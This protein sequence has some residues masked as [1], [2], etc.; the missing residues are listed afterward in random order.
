[1]RSTFSKFCEHR[2]CCAA[3]V[4]AIKLERQQPGHTSECVEALIANPVA[5]QIQMPER[6]QRCKSLRR[7]VPNRVVP[8]IKLGQ[9]RQV[10]SEHVSTPVPN[11]VVMQ[12]QSAQGG[13]ARKRLCT[14]VAHAGRV[15][16]QVRHMGQ[17]ARAPNDR[18]HALIVK[19]VIFRR[20]QRSER[21]H[22]RAQFTQ[23]LTTPQII[24]GKI[25][26]GQLG[27][28]RKRRAP[29]LLTLFVLMS[30]CVR[31]LIESGVSQRELGGTCVSKCVGPEREFAQRCEAREHAH[32]LGADVVVVQIQL[33]QQS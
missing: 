21:S 13:Q 15:E 27:Q 33:R 12:E 10:A 6:G 11:A 14:C 23:A 5:I 32:T 29:V 19:F 8:D 26:A 22:T 30:R 1:M 2:R 16:L 3:C 7:V 28:R 9:V 17:S 25:Q 18:T 24:E 31:A 20:V 4:V